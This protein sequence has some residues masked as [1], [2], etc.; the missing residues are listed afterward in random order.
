MTG[1]AHWLPNFNV[2]FGFQKT[3]SFLGVSAPPSENGGIS[4]NLKILNF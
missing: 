1:L 2:D 4:I 3:P